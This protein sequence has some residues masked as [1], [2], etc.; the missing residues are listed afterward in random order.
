MYKNLQE[1]TLREIN[2]NSLLSKEV[3]ALA[4]VLGYKFNLKEC[5][6]KGSNGF[7][8]K[9][10]DYLIDGKFKTLLRAY[11]NS[12]WSIDS[13][14]LALRVAYRQNVLTRDVVEDAFIGFAERISSIEPDE[15]YS[16]EFLHY[17]NDRREKFCLSG[18]K[19]AKPTRVHVVRR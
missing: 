19:E 7:R 11:V 1:S 4:K 3:S 12:S 9:R 16:V 10:N 13:T 14:S 8:S 2:S 6:L 15:R 18:G 5:T 17:I